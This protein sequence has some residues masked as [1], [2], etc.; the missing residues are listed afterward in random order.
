MHA[1]L[2]SRHFQNIS[3]QAFRDFPERGFQGGCRFSRPEDDVLRHSRYWT[4]NDTYTPSVAS[5]PVV[6]GEYAYAGAVTGHFGHY[7]AE[8]SHRF[9]PTL[10]RTKPQPWL[11]IAKES[12]RSGAYQGL[13]RTAQEVADYF[14]IRSENIVIVSRDSIVQGLYVSEQGSDLGGG[15]K[16]G[17]VDDLGSYADERLQNIHR[18]DAIIP[19]VYVSRSSVLTGG[20]FLGERYFERIL[21]KEGFFI[22]KPEQYALTQQMDIYRKADIVVFA[23][24]SACHGIELLGRKSLHRCY[25]RSRRKEAEVS[26]FVKIFTQRTE[27]FEV[28]QEFYSLGSFLHNE[29]TGTPWEHLNVCLYHPAALVDFCRSHQISTLK[30]FDKKKYLASAAKDLIRILIANRKNQRAKINYRAALRVIGKYLS[31]GSQF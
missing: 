4:P 22:F 10:L 20:T 12:A 31:Y 8:M 14:L 1:N 3:V 5:E 16:E 24:G 6:E 11:Y 28:L 2:V 19:K 27:T 18:R 26:A 17:Y 21:E 25:F 7:M 9:L 23:D 30:S 15:P 13:P 29:T